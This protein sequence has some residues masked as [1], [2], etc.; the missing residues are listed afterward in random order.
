[1]AGNYTTALRAFPFFV[2]LVKKLLDAVLLDM[3]EVFNH[4]HSVIRPVSFIQLDEV[5]A[6]KV[7]TFITI[8]YLFVT[9]KL[10]IPYDISTLPVSRAAAR[11][12]G[13][14]NSFIAYLVL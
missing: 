7:S 14:S 1:V 9:Q 10:A 4:T 13:Y 12:V 8:S 5:L 6:G 2:L 11:A 3:A